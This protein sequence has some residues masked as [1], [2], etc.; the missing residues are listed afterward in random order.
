MKL[1]NY[2]KSAKN[3]R[4]AILLLGIASTIWFLVRVIPKPSRASYPC[5]KVAAP[6]MSGFVIYLI[7]M[8]GSVWAFRKAYDKVFKMKFLAASIFL[9]LAVSLSVVFFTTDVRT[10]FASPNIAVAD[11]PNTP[12]G[13]AKGIFPGRVVW[14]M[15]KNATNEDCE[16]E[17]SDYWFM[18]ENTNQT[19]VDTMLANGLKS[20]SGQKTIA[21][22]WDAVFKYFNSNHAKGAVGYTSGEKIVIKVNLTTMGSGG[23][24]YDE[25][26]DITPQLA[27][28]LLK[29]LIDTMNIS[30]SDITI[31]DPFRGM[32]NEVFNPCHTKYPDVH[33]IEGAGA[34]GREQTAI[35]ADDVFFTSDDEFQSR[36]PQAYLDA[37]Y[38]INMP[39]LKTHN[40]AG[41]TIAAKNHQ[42]SV[43]GP[44]QTATSQ[45]MGP[46]LHYDY[47]V[48][49][50]PENQVMGIYRHIVDYIAHNKL[51]GNTLLYI[52]DAIWSGR[53]WDGVVEKWQMSPFNDDWTS[54]LFVSQDPV[55]LE[56]VGFDFLYNEYKDYPD[57]HG[58]ANYPLV[59]G[60]QD[61]IHQAADPA[62]WPAGIQYDPSTSD[63]SSPVGS[64]GVHEH[65]NNTTDKKYTRN[66]GSGTGIELFTVF[67]SITNNVID[68]P[69][70]EVK[71][72]RVFPN[73][74]KDI[75]VLKYM[76]SE[77][78][79]IHVELL[80]LDGKMV[81]NTGN[82]KQS[83]GLNTLSL[84][85]ADYKLPE[86]TYICRVIADD[87]I[88]NALT[89]KIV[90]EK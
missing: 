12:M 80:S 54:S 3:S 81:V 4:L 26:M 76:L 21:S 84:H 36:L 46:Y 86:G 48:D 8:T 79:N 43:I 20:I 88:S 78:S 64:L 61:Y 7:S 5:M 42:G 14:V 77:N 38:L 11:E 66:L 2:L 44:D 73:P 45:Y 30:Q 13:V 1:I 29:E 33:Y 18:D 60:V 32:P 27:L 70:E 83:A 85:I 34:S 90:I 41:I 6:I 49:G 53:N 74:V 58:N 62:N 68:Q 55:A 19:V 24:H 67:T 72:L 23:R 51:G 87:K 15:D 71:G 28:S 22:A 25:A 37:A 59:S 63:H 9:A 40:S 82:V 31:G 57:S 50:G 52:V 35:S 16:N 69:I 89:S 65:W 39:C 17:T 47:P 10:V 75:I 56:S